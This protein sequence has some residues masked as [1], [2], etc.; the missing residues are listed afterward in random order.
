MAM[1]TA[2]RQVQHGEADRWRQIEEVFRQNAPHLIR[3]GTIL[4][5]QVAGRRTW[6][7]RFVVHQD[8]RTVHRSVFLCRDDEP[9]LLE[10]ARDLLKRYRERAGWAK[11]LALFAR[12]AG[13]ARAA[14]RRL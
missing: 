7:L 6:V 5:K 2:R 3:Q 8:G 11:E 14:L 9:A 13:A 10:K 12:I 1:A 4:S